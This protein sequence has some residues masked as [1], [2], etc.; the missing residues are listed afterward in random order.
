MFQT[1]TH[2]LYLD[3]GRQL[4]TIYSSTV[5]AA[6]GLPFLGTAAGWATTLRLGA[7]SRARQTREHAPVISEAEVRRQERWT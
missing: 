4:E 7:F 5:A 6:A 2:C 1:T 3:E